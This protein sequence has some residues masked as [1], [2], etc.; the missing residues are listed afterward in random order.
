MR[1]AG[2][3]AKSAEAVTRFLD[4]VQEAALPT[5]QC[6]TAPDGS[7]LVLDGEVFAV[8]EPAT[9]S[10]VSPRSEADRLPVETFIFRYTDYQG[11]F[12]E[13]EEARKTAGHFGV[14]HHE[15]PFSPTDIS[16]NLEWMVQSYGEPFTYRLH[17]VMLAKLAGTGIGGLLNGAGPDGWY[18]NKF[19]VYGVYCGRVPGMLRALGDAAIPLGRRVLRRAVEAAEGRKTSRILAPCAGPDC[20]SRYSLL[21]EAVMVETP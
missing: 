3:H 19:N 2:I 11:E 10:A 15:I 21:A 1:V 20:G 9:D 8:P 6:A 5:V 4:A 16:D 13:L 18:L 14:T 12:N 17:S 7:F